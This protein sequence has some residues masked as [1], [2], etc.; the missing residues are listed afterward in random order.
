MLKNRGYNVYGIDITEKAIKI[1][2]TRGIKARQ[3]NVKLG[4]DFD[5]QFFDIVIASEIIEHLYDTDYFLEEIKRVLKRGGYLFLTTP[6]L[7]SLKNRFR[8]LFGMYPQY[9]EFRLSR[10][11]AGHIRN[12]TVS[13]LKSQLLEHGFD[14]IKISSPN[15]IFPMTKN[16]PFL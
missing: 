8:L 1:A 10:N 4:I 9:S 14:I 13:A 2:R 11:G 16:I 15:I 5:D 3:C 7:A 12:Y 6:N